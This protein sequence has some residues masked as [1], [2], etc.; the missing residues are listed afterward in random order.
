MCTDTQM[1]CNVFVTRPFYNSGSDWGLGI[2][3][4]G[5]VLYSHLAVSYITL[6]WQRP[7]IKTLARQRPPW[8]LCFQ[9]RP[10][11]SS[12]YKDFSYLLS[13]VYVRQFSLPYTARACE[14]LQWRFS[15][16]IDEWKIRYWVIQRIIVSKEA[17]VQLGVYHCTVPSQWT[18]FSILPCSP[19]IFLYWKRT[20][21]TTV[22]KMSFVTTQR[23]SV[24]HY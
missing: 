9:I 14:R 24:L 18:C 8:S 13:T 17:V 12:K 11:T 6:L 15:P 5:L 23:Q 7:G 20:V 16:D 4:G 2:V 21:L 10:T 1:F 3:R 19:N 22:F